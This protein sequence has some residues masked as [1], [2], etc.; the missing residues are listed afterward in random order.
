[1]MILAARFY[2]GVLLIGCIFLPISGAVEAQTRSK[3]AP[4]GYWKA[5]ED[6]LGRKGVPSAGDV[7]RFGFP[8]TDLSVVVDGVT[9]KP[10]L[11]LG[12][13]VAFKR[14]G[15]HVMVMGDLVL[16]EDEVVPVMASLQQNGVEQTALHNHVLD[17]TPRVMYMHIRA[18][19]NPGR[20]ARAVKTA[21]EFTETP[22]GPPT[23]A[24]P[25]TAA[26]TEPAPAFDLDTA[27]IAKVMGVRGKTNG[28]VYQLSIPRREK[29][30]EEKREVTAAMG[31]ATAINFQPV[32]EG[33]AAVT[34]DFVL[35][36]REVN[37]VIWALSENGIAVTAIHSHM[38]NEQPRLFFLHFWAIDDG[39]KLARGLRAA[40]D[41]TRRRR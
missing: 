14:M 6:V 41:R 28:G 21:L 37:P 23:T 27:A 17:E 35:I 36:G 11:A 7:V 24:A 13:W 22:L 10:A 38:I 29:I 9:L 34:G 30:L 26:P 33:K 40:L 8:R 19:G 15:D 1:L 39:V 32:G 31:V 16:L 20:I 18:I 5:V 4:P 12:S 25:A 2:A 3:A